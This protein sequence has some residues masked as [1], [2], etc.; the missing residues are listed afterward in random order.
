MSL[1][2]VGH[3]SYVSNIYDGWVISEASTEPIVYVTVPKRHEHKFMGN[4]M[5]Y[6]LDFTFTSLRPHNDIKKTKDSSITTIIR[7]GTD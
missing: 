1:Y 5:N 2:L 3:R 6:Y 4:K 7:H